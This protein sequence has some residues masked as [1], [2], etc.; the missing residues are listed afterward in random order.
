M[1]TSAPHW[2]HRLQP[3]S[4]ITWERMETLLLDQSHHP[5][6]QRMVTP[7]LRSIAERARFLPVEDSWSAILALAWLTG[8]DE[9]AVS[10]SL[11]GGGMT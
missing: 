3:L 11:L 5:D 10:I 4:T 9:A 7:R 1:L 6:G 2:S 8:G